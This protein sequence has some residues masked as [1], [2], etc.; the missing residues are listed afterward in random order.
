MKKFILI[1]LILLLINSISI[2][3]QIQGSDYS[4]EYSKDTISASIQNSNLNE[5][6]KNPLLIINGFIWGFDSTVL[7][8][9]NP[10]DIDKINVLKDEAATQLYKDFG[11]N[12]V[13][14]IT[15]KD[16]SINNIEKFKTAYGL[17]DSNSKE[18]KISGIIYDIKK[19]II[20][21][22]LIKN[23][24]RKES[25]KSDSNGNYSIIARENDL[26][27]FLADGFK[28]STLRIKGNKINVV[29]SIKPESEI[30]VK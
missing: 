1:S 18:Q 14:L 24:N 7:S 5:K 29:L 4:S 17:H 23:L 16:T 27:V 26:V 25:S 6:T 3:A 11:K 22:V 10:K 15:L 8:I 30:Q 19:N 20:P 21:N 13:L 2:H 9:I 28:M 12:G